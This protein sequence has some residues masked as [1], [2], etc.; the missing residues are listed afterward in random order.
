MISQVC[1]LLSVATCI[2]TLLMS[3]LGE[4]GLLLLVVQVQVLGSSVHFPL[5]NTSSLLELNAS[6]KWKVVFGFKGA[7]LASRTPAP[8]TPGSQSPLAR[9]AVPAT[10]SPPIPKPPAGTV[11]GATPVGGGTARVI[12][13]NRA[14]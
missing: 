8:L 10:S 2:K 13:G 9:P 12:N 6:T 3:V 5:E 1:R 7:P 11:P 4:G 14:T